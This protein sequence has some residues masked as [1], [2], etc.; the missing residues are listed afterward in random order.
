MVRVITNK[1]QLCKSNK[2][3]VTEKGHLDNA[4]DEKYKNDKMI[5]FSNNI[6]F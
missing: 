5:K 6:I 1:K 4:I 3:Q 2:L